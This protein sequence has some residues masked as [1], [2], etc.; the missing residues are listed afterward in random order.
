V[1]RASLLTFIWI[2]GLIPRPPAWSAEK[3]LWQFG[4]PDHSDHEF[5]SWPDAQAREPIVVRVGSGNEE[6]AWPK[7]HPGSAN[8]A[9][10]ARP[11]PY[12]LVFELAQALSPRAGLPTRSG[13]VRFLDSG[14]V[15]RTPETGVP[16]GA[17]KR[18]PLHGAFY[19]NLSL[20]FRHPR[21]P[22]MQVEINGHR[23]IYYLSP[24]ASVALGDETDAFNPIH[25]AE[26]RRIV[27]PARYFRAGENHL[28]LTCLDEP[29]TVV[30]HSTAGGPGDSGVYYDAL[31]LSHDPDASPMEELQI[32]FE[33]T[34][35]FRRSSGSLEEECELTVRYPEG[36]RGAKARLTLKGFTSDIKAAKKAEFGE[37]RYQ[38]Y[39]PE[40]VPA[41]EAQLE[42]VNSWAAGVKRLSH[43]SFTAEF[44][45]RRKWRVFY[46][47]NEHLDIGYTDYQAKV[48]EVYSRNLDRLLDVFASHPNYRFNIDGSW[49]LQEWLATRTAQQASRLAEQARAGR[50]GVNAFYGVFL[51]GLL[52]LEEFFR[53]LYLSKELEAHYG[54]PFDSAW[55][56]DVPSYSWTLPS[57]LAAAGIRYFAGGANQ[58]RGPLNAF[59]HWNIRSPF[60][61]EGP[62]GQRV[63][64]FYAYHYHQLRAVFGV[65]PSIEAGAS[66]LPI[67]LQP[68]ERAD[69]A[70][71]AVLLYGTEAENVP[72][73][74]LDAEL[75]PHWNAQYAYPQV[76]PCRFAD[77]FRYVEERYA[78]RLPVAR[79]DGGAYW[80]VGA[81]TDAAATSRY[82]EGQTRAL[83]AEA[84]ATLTSSLDRTLRFP[85]GL[86]RDI[87]N[88]LLLYNDHTVTDYRGSRQPEHDE[89]V[90][91]LE[92]K[93]SRTTR[94]ALEI[95][96]LMRRSLS[97]LAD[98]VQTEGENLVVF[99]PL[100][101]RRSG[102]VRCQVDPGTTLTDTASNQ[103]VA[104]EVVESRDGYQTIRFWA[105]GV[106][107]I[108]YKVYRLGRGPVTQPGRTEPESNVVQNKFYR[109]T[110]DPTRAAIK[111]LY[112]K[113]LGRE[114]VD[115][116]S[117][118]LVNE[119]LY[120]TGGGSEKGRGEDEEATQ[121]I[122]LAR[123]LP[124]AEL[125]VHHPKQGQMLSVEKTPWGHVV[126]FAAQALHTPQIETEIFLPDDDKRI[127]IRNRIHKELV[128]AKEAAY[129][130][131]PWAATNAVFRFDIADGWVDPEKDL[132]AGAGNEWFAVQHG[133]NVEDATA[134]ITLAVVDAPVVSLSDINRGHWPEKFS[135]T[136]AAV[137]SHALNNYWFTG[138][139]AGQSGDFVFRYA[140]TSGRRFDPQEATRFG[141]ETRSPLE[142]S[143]IRDS[144]KGAWIKGD[145][146][147]AGAS[148]VELEPENLIV[149]ALKA[150]EDGQGLVVRV[151]ETSGKATQGKLSF[152]FF[153]VASAQ[154]ANAVEAPGKQLEADAHSVRF[155]IR[156]L[157]VLTI[158]VQTR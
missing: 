60:W 108:G 150:A 95:D 20:L 139:P 7:F 118:Y 76:I 114:L 40:G 6:K 106:P 16:P 25:S 70:P 84:L 117:P 153:P 138:T 18:E 34:V 23:G 19:L 73:D 43:Q 30:R 119:Y 146:P 74:Y 41:G 112:D 111:S 35:F 12:T 57:A 52:S 142:V 110:F 158:R 69:Y 156:P 155:Q 126:R 92:V 79:G 86:N 68:Y 67:F 17:T 121:L 49:V 103:L 93:E 102:L 122:H 105:R 100:S 125:T 48:A 32:S 1:R 85:L 99:N 98:Q 63:L 97:Q 148:L 65:P 71:D 27:L 15:H 5:T 140:I 24:N 137:F 39:V 51:T 56:T 59:G 141:R 72:L 9:M 123:H 124:F 116:S 64:A 91:Q 109:I 113:E 2:V 29:A 21:I 151:L 133:V 129:F 145:L 28:T 136:S 75:A 33:P 10:G 143:Q 87:W 81:G 107:A 11:Y 96:E 14:G 8:E 130:A 53:G 36:W 104:Y 50:I 55:V 134:A 3:V 149:S 147:A 47:P 22:V 135:K 132:L 31:S 88:N 94:A 115:P 62:D 46:A 58:T 42:L 13:H 4:K 61:W 26:Q 38:V 44:V 90:G 131:F 80:E 45:P 128:Y 77:Y 82:R 157:Q 83:A 66:A 120:V 89:M 54:I 127:Q 101:W 78:A 144:D 37:V 152:P 154:E